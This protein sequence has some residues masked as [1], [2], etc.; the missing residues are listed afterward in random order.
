MVTRNKKKETSA[1]PP[2]ARMDLSNSETS[3]PGHKYVMSRFHHECDCV[4]GGG[5]CGVKGR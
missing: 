4:G 2:N 1:M 3:S 5:A